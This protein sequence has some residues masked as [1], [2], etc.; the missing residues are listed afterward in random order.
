M[1]VMR[2]RILVLGA[3][4]IGGYFG[5]RLAEARADVTFLVRAAR[6]ERLARDGLRIESPF[7]AAHIPVRTVRA[8]T[9]EG[10]FDVVLIACKA[11]DL[12]AAIADVTPAVGPQTAV[13]PL[14][15]GLAH[16]DRLNDVFG[17]SRVLGGLAK[18]QAA[19]SEDGTIR[20]LNDWRFVV[21]GEQNG[22]LSPRVL[23]LQ[24]AFAGALG[25]E[26]EAVS[27]IRQRM[28]EK[29]VHLATAAAMTCL[30]RASVGDIVRT[31]DGARQFA[32][33]FDAVCAIAGHEG[34]AP[35]A[36]FV[37]SYREVFSDPA[38]AY[39]TS[40]LRDIRQGRRIEGDHIVGYVRDKARRHG[41][42][43]PEL[44]LAFTHLKAYEQ[45][46]A[47]SSPRREPVPSTAEQSR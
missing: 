24:A 3:G 45:W 47:R 1:T 36:D 23:A 34:F 35:G 7:G 17:A 33:L 14:L 21:F 41:I 4:G 20:Q 37:R 12:E 19:V 26:A 25:V 31:P 16:L 13:L 10:P 9:L 22:T 27:D 39:E 32:E 2:Q 40:M 30:M 38:S 11:Y 42:T 8:E 15:N 43:S 5:G 46:L 6:Q 29:L 44:E 28:W 18:I